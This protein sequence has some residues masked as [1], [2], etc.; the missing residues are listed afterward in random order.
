MSVAIHLT[1]LLFAGTSAHAANC[2][3]PTSF[4]VV[5]L[6]DALNVRDVSDDGRAVGNSSGDRAMLWD[7]DGTYT[8]LG[9]D[10]FAESISRNGRFVVGNADTIVGR[11]A[12]LWDLQTGATSFLPPLP[13]Y[14]GANGWGV[15]DQGQAVGSS[16]GGNDLVATMWEQGVASDLSVH[17][18]GPATYTD[19]LDISNGG[20]IVGVVAPTPSRLRSW[21]WTG[22]QAFLLPT[23]G[24]S[25][26]IAIHVADGPFAA[27]MALPVSGSHEEAAIWSPS[28]SRRFPAGFAEVRG[29]NACGWAV[30]SQW[31][32]VLGMDEPRLWVGNQSLVL[33]NLPDMP[34]NIV[35]AEAIS[36][37]GHLVVA[38]RFGASWLLIPVR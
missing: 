36:D 12:V 14:T 23:L 38:E 37:E 3:P 34:P 15:N 5:E 7:V 25:D 27:G 35:R 10:A 30:G 29:L 9:D 11:Q 16:F 20:L 6:Q 31:N 17:V 32:P 18:P 13:G 4:D 26:A 22:Q 8:V 28:G 19:A 21:V 1:A 2:T 33:S 24:A